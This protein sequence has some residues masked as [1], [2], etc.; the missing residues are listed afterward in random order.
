MNDFLLDFIQG[1]EDSGRYQTIR[2]FHGDRFVA[3]DDLGR[4]GFEHFADLTDSLLVENDKVSWWMHTKMPETHLV[5]IELKYAGLRGKIPEVRV[6]NG[7]KSDELL[8]SDILGN[9][10]EV[11]P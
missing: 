7:A 1:L 8:I 5:E 2:V 9:L 3:L 10:K 4:S 11:Y 6:P